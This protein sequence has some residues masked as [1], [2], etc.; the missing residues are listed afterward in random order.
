VP[1][2][3]PLG[4]RRLALVLLAA[5]AAL[6]VPLAPDPAGAD[7]PTL[8]SDVTLSPDGRLHELTLASP[9][10]GRETKVRVLLP[11]GYDATTRT[12][13]VLYLLHGAGDDHTGW[14][15]N[16]DVE[17]AT[18]GL[19]LIV[20][21]PDAGKAPDAGWYSDWV[22]GPAWESYHVGELVPHVDSSYRTVAQREGRAL[23][24]LSMGG[25]GAM[26]Y[27]A[28]HPH[29]F[30][31]AA[32]F[33]GA[34]DNSMGSVAQAEA[35]KLAHERF[36]TPDDRVWGP[37]A[38]SEVRWRDHN[39]PDLSTNLRWTALW[40]STGNGVPRPGDNPVDAPTEAG[41]YAMN[42]ALHDDLT[43]E[44]IA[45]V[46][47]DRGYGTHAWNYW[48]ADL[49]DALPFLMGAFDHPPARPAAFD[50]RRAEAAFAPWG[51]QFTARRQAMEFLDLTAVSAAGMRARGSGALDVVTA[52]L[53]PPGSRHRVTVAWSKSTTR[54][55]STTVATAD[56]EGRLRFTVDLGPSHTAQ[57]YTAEG[58]LAEAAGGPDYW[59]DATVAVA[60]LPNRS[61]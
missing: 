51:W 7:T 13:P 40:M 15:E 27:A 49:H 53:Y 52:P 21:M 55:R 24:G 29:L 57:Q 16:T 17:E 61:R 9:A 6:V 46:W 44:G 42:V 12:Y 41:V 45:H 54:F 19:D 34:V 22:D 33:S 3:S 25:F 30:A 2:D 32:S 43:A 36:G 35:F 11:A 26:S 20:V 60:A 39:P 50:H 58:R 5:L 59:T 4:T 48:Q 56:A 23:A 28:R 14:T 1:P 47:R 38:T 8:R 10:L 31:A 18:A 37:Y